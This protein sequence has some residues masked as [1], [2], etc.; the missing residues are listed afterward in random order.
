MSI[1]HYCPSCSH[2]LLRHV[3][4]R[5]VY[6]RCGHCREEFSA[7]HPYLK[8]SSQP[9]NHLQ[10]NVVSLSSLSSLEMIVFSAVS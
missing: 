9:N 3:N 8:I 10:H 7:N 4:I 2:P 6:W 1:S 5:G